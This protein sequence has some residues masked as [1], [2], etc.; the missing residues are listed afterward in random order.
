MSA[1]ALSRLM[2]GKQDVLHCCA[3]VAGAI[4]HVHEHVVAHIEAGI[5]RLGI[6]VDE[7]GEGIFAPMGVAAFGWLLLDELLLFLRVVLRLFLGLYVLDHV[8]RSLGPDIADVVK[9]LTPGAP[10]DL[11]KLANLE[12]AGTYAVVLAQL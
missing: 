5:Q 4:E 12:G 1:L 9:P 3:P 7:L 8:G 6:T 10:C 11:L 2:I